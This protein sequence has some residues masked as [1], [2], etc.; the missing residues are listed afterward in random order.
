MKIIPVIDIK[1][2]HAVLAKQGQ[3]KNYQ[4]LS[5]LLCPYS[6][7]N[8]VI[9][10]YLS[11]GNFSK[12]YIADLDSLMGTGNNIICINSIFRSFPNIQFMVDCGVIQPDYQPL[13]KNQ[14]LPVLGT[15][16]FDA[17][18]LEALNKNFILSL[19]FSSHNKAMGKRVLY[20]M[21]ELWPKEIIIMTLALVG[22]NCGADFQK[23]NHY[24][25]RY[26]SYDFIAAGGVRDL[27]DLI[28]L[29]NLGIRQVLVATALHTQK[30][31]K[32]DLAQLASAS[33]C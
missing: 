19:D 30:I 10:A 28:Q 31:K 3:R 13:K 25:Q 18:T 12:F 32:S 29:K 9:E 20:N 14:Y 1:S 8:V 4:P 15:E 33:F 23:I 7:P 27:N 22:K 11:I 2:G 26:P 21:P 5:T 24:I 17:K 6:D 16:S